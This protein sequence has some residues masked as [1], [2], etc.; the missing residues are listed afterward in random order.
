VLCVNADDMGWTKDITDRIIECHSQGS[1]HSVSLIT[2]MIDSERAA[3]LAG[4]TRM[5][6]GLHVNFDQSLTSTKTPAKLREHHRTVSNYLQ[7]S[8]WNQ[9]LYNPL[10]RNAFDYVFQAQWDEFYRLCGIHPA[11]LDGHHHMH[12]CMNMLASDKLPRGIRIRRNF[13]FDP[14]E[15]NPVNRLYRYLV[16]RWLI[17][18]FNC[19]DFFFSISPVEHKRLQRVVSLS[20]SADVELMVHP[21]VEEEYRYLLSEEWSNLMAEAQLEEMLG[22]R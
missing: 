5:D 2:F 19:T 22:V 4:E 21:G 8:K 14:T 7:A 16:D 10:L 11:R 13:T 18:R 1:L 15:K 6:I 9:V 12:L 3:N 20:T 17:S